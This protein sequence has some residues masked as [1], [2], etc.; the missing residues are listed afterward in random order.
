MLL[1]SY[2]HLHPLLETKSSF[3]NIYDENNRLDIFEIMI[4]TNE[5]AKDTTTIHG[6]FY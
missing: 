5:L 3:V 2:H 4:S 6:F 1:K